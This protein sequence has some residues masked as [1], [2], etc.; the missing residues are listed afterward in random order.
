MEEEHLE[1]WKFMI[2]KAQCLFGELQT[3]KIKVSFGKFQP[4]GFQFN[5]KSKKLE[6]G[7]VKS[8]EDKCHK[9]A[10]R[11]VIEASEKDYL[12]TQEGLKKL[13]S[14]IKDWFLSKSTFVGEADS[15]LDLQAKEGSKFLYQDLYSVM[16]KYNLWE[17]GKKTAK[18]YIL[19]PSSERWIK[20]M[21]IC[22]AEMGLIDF[23]EKIPRVKEIFAGIASKENRKKYILSRL[24]FL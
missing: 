5:K 4:K 11:L 22:M 10:E 20:G 24:A 2:L 19:N 18:E 14:E 13:K 12:D 21:R 23:N 6:E 16:K 8:I 17:L 3:L 15:K 7:K 1:F 9:Y